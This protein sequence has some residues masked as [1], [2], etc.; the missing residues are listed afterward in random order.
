MKLRTL[1]TAT[2]M[3]ASAPAPDRLYHILLLFFAAANLMA[4]SDA[5]F[6]GSRLLG[7]SRALEASCPGTCQLCTS[8]WLRG[9]YVTHHCGGLYVCCESYVQPVNEAEARKIDAYYYLWGHSNS[10]NGPIAPSSANAVVKDE[11]VGDQ[12]RL[13]EIHF[14]PVV[15]DPKCGRPRISSR[16]VV[17]G[18]AAGF[19]V[20]PWQAMIRVKRTR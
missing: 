2:T 9:G 16:R 10:V 13:Q 15:N 19:G 7:P 1:K 8:C 20:Y 11:P 17:G 18:S 14:G 4:T 12:R 5:V 3:A 6:F